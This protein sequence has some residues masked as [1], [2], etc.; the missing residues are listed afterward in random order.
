MAARTPRRAK[1]PRRSYGAGADRALNLWVALARCNATVSRV[2]ARDIARY[3]L[4]QAQFA[5]LE[6]LYHKGPMPL[7]SIGEK[8]LV[9]SGNVTFVADQLEKSGLLV[10]QRSA[11]DRRVVIARL[12]AR[13]RALIQ[14][15][16]PQHAATIESAAGALSPREQGEL[17]RLLKKWGKGAAGD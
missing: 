13:G 7:C 10:R 5:V 15:I 3:G 17:A 2:S 11:Q 9:T 12:S 14:R 1:A 4:T 16:F 8:L 6:A